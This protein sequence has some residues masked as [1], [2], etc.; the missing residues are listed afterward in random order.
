MTMWMVLISG[1]FALG[2]TSASSISG[3]NL[4]A[5]LGDPIEVGYLPDPGHWQLQVDLIFDPQ[6]PPMVKH[7]KS[8]QFPTGA[9]ILLDAEQPFP[10]PLWEEFLIV[11]GPPVIDWHELIRT[12]GWEWRVPDPNDPAQS[13]ITKNGQPWPSQSTSMGNPATLWVDFPPILPGE[14]L[15]VHKALLWVGTENNRIWG[16]NALNDGTAIDESFIRVIQYPTPEPT[17]ALL[18]CLGLVALLINRRP[19]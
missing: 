11:D 8:P 15:D 7:F 16:D 12:P 1:G 17:S 3:F 19:N 4:E 2:Q 13:L 18:L 9:P 10:Q 5:P 14:V 6:A